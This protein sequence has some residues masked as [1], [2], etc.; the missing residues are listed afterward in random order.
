[1]ETIICAGFIFCVA[2][3]NFT[4]GAYA[5]LTAPLGEKIGKAHKDLNRQNYAP[6]SGY[7]LHWDEQD[8]G[9]GLR[10]NKDG[11]RRATFAHLY[12]SHDARRAD[13]RS[14]ACSALMQSVSATQ[15]PKICRS[16][17]RKNFNRGV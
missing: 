8:R 16:P 4:G 5:V 14:T 15:V 12:I 2:C 11:K 13:A 7:D 3:H 6:E 17:D 9:F 10:V 1:M